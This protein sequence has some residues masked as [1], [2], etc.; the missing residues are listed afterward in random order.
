MRAASPAGLRRISDGVGDT[1]TVTG[2]FAP[3]PSGELHVGNL[4]TAM[5]AWLVARS[6]GER[7]VVRLDDLDVANTSEEHAAVQLRD[8]AA[9]GLEWDGAVVRQSERFHRYRDVIEWLVAAGLTYPCFCSRRE[10]R[11]AATAPHG[12]TPDGAYSGTCRHLSEAERR[13]RERDRP[14][15]LRLR[16]DA[17]VLTVDDEVAGQYVG[18]VDDFVLRRNDGVPAYNLAVVVDDLDQ[19]V[20]H[21]VRGNDLLSST[22]RHLLLQAL[23][24]AR[25]PRYLHVP[26]VVGPD[27][28]RLAKRDGAVT[29]AD[30]A[31]AGA[32]AAAV[33]RALVAS[34]ELA[35][36]A[37]TTNDE[38]IEQFRA[39]G[40]GRLAGPPIAL[41]CLA[42]W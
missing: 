41:D 16:T 4:R 6:G 12:D 33:R 20:T 34:L 19:H 30:L 10:I 14:P 40:V 24:G 17:E 18:R 21:V 28:D 8:L 29:L 39:V 2:R 31:A 1:D 13:R 22:P 42:R 5:I 7:F 37:P 27:G 9:I 35:Q 3:S 25:P 38:L 36:P 23:L 32:S 15:A 26:L 11:E